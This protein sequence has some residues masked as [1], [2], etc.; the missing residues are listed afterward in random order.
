MVDEGVLGVVLD[1]F[2]AEFFGFGIH[3]LLLCWVAFVL[4]VCDAWFDRATLHHLDKK[5]YKLHHTHTQL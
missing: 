2:C 4:G 3:Q 5:L 1:F